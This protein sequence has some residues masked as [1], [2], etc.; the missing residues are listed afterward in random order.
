MGV[1]YE[2]RATGKLAEGYREHLIAPDCE[3]KAEARKY[4]KRRQNIVK[5]MLDGLIPM[6]ER[7]LTWYNQK[8]LE[9][10]EIIGYYSVDFLC[11]VL[12][13]D[14]KKRGN[15]TLDKMETHTLF[16]KS[17]FGME[18]DIK[19]LKRIDIEAM[20][21]ELRT[22]T[23]KKEETLSNSTINRYLSSIR[24]AFNILIDDEN[25]DIWVNPCRGVKKLPEDNQKKTIIPK[26][27]DEAF[28][29][30]FTSRSEI[31]RDMFELNLNTGL[32]IS[33]ITRLNKVQIYLGERRIKIE[34]KD[35]KGKK[36][37]D[38]YINDRALELILKYYYNARFY[39][40]INPKTGEP[41]KDLRKSFKN[42]AKKIGMPNLTIHDLRR[43]FGTR[44]YKDT[45]DIDLTRE[46]LDQSDISTTMRYIATKKREVDS[47]I[48][49]L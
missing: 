27:L 39:L 17:Y 36:N 49:N 14:Y 9:H 32:R 18:K 41:F 24:R 37:I 26:S 1:Y 33:N 25:I 19:T 22:H 3:T 31:Q 44:I 16:F 7:V 13:E 40:F 30:S 6:D 29:S 46:A 47:A 11:K 10:K 2:I 35:N 34:P 48:K 15:K 45:K 38:K 23:N 43:S 20:I 4:G 8:L 28:L 42:A 5:A 12:V 21:N